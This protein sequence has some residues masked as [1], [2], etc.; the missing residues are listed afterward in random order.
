MLYQVKAADGSLLNAHFH[1]VG[2]TAWFLS[3]GGK[4]GEGSSNADYGPA[5]R[6]L[7]ERLNAAT[8]GI[9][10]IWVDSSSVQ[11]IPLLDRKI[12]TPAEWLESPQSAFTLL[13]RRM[14][15]VGQ[16]A[17]SSAKPGGNSTRKLR[18]DLA[19]K[20]G[21]SQIVGVLGGV[22]SNKDMRSLDRLPAEMLQHVT[23]KHVWAAV[24][25]LLNGHPLE[26][27]GPSTDFDLLAD[28]GQRLPPKA[29]FGVAASEALGFQVIPDHFTG[30]ID[31]LCFR[32]LT[33]SDY[34]IVAK[35]ESAPSISIP[36]S[37]DASWV[38]GN[39]KLVTHLKRERAKGLSQAKKADF[40]ALNG[41]LHCER[42]G[43]DP[44]AKYGEL[45]EACVE[46]HHRDM[47]VKDM[48]PD[49]ITTLDELQCLCAN[50]HRIV[51]RELKLL[52]IGSLGK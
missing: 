23:P 18:I 48:E 41:K 44:V 3:R 40:K 37:E 52:L 51:H 31:T 16:S 7:L 49:H 46:V 10:G 12:L 36:G 32:I 29:V 20:M 22:A 8:I 5:L 17:T 6:L 28:D 39:P 42:C 34:T 24:Q 2:K 43:I 45:G 14:K 26:P 9:E 38:E 13:S 21:E 15:A 19:T 47:Q 4:K 33:E 30:G 50:C 11:G 27:F 1:L 35:D 25:K